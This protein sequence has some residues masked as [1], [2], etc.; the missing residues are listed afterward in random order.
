MVCSDHQRSGIGLRNRACDCF[1]S[2]RS[3]PGGACSRMYPRL[4]S[5][6][7]VGV[8]LPCCA[9][10][11]TS[12]SVRS[13]TLW[14]YFFSILGVGVTTTPTPSCRGHIY[15]NPFLSWSHLPQPLLVLRRGFDPNP[16]PFPS[17]GEGMQ[18]VAF[19]DFFS[20]WQSRNKFHFAHLA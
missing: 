16:R 10:H 12:T 17:P 5:G 19:G 20:P 7:P 9:W 6:D 1:C 13:V 15:P 3:R 18:P 2:L 14:C 8:M 11:H 4:H